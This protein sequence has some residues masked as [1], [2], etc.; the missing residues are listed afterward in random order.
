MTDR[1]RQITELFRDWHSGT[2]SRRQLI[3]RG[4]ALGISAFMLAP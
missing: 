4:S 1:N 3:T 2:I